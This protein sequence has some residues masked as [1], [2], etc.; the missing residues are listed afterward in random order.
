M[1]VGVSIMSAEEI[2]ELIRLLEDIAEPVYVMYKV[3]PLS[4]DPNGEM[5]LDV[6][7][8][9][10]AD[11]IVTIN[12]KHFRVAGQDLGIPILAPAEVLQRLEQSHVY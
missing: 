10:R 5:F 8:N 1:R 4:V 6:A 11:A 3:R 9:G 12:K 7:N 2:E